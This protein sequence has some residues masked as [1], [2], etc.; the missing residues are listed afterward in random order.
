MNVL[1][2]IQI[3]TKTSKN[4]IRWA[5]WGG[6]DKRTNSEERLQLEQELLLVETGVDKLDHDLEAIEE[7]IARMTAPLPSSKP[8]DHTNL[9]NRAFLSFEDM[10]SLH[11]DADTVIV[12]RAPAN[13]VCQHTDYA[14][15]VPKTNMQH[16]IFL[17]SP[18]PPIQVTL[19][20]PENCPMVK[21]VHKV[22][23]GRG[24]RA[25]R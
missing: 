23:A 4:R 24:A 13:T 18:G 2:G 12:M 9:D 14:A 3:V 6:D 21:S 25:G 7:Q 10:R 20:Q 15:L 8:E 16:Q 22:D 1:E 19:V 5:Q 11:T 17:R